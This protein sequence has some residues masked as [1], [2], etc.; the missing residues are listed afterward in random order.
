MLLS[1][2]NSYAAPIFA[3]AAGILGGWLLRCQFGNRLPSFLRSRRRS[4]D[5]AGGADACAAT[6]NPVL[7][8]IDQTTPTRNSIEGVAA[9]S[10]RNTFSLAL[11]RHLPEAAR[12]GAALSVMFVRIDNPRRP[13]D[14]NVL[15]MDNRILDAT[16]KLFVGLVRVTDWV[17]RFDATTFAFLLT[18]TEHASALMVAE[19]CARSF[20]PW[21]CL[22]AR[23]PF[24]SLLASE[25]R[26]SCSATVVL[27]SCTAPR[28]P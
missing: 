24:G 17:A 12:R 13:G 27:R 25:R 28:K 9:P 14:R 15:P 23:G 11:D 6:V 19:R 2:T 8:D 22:P 20:P 18:D 5:F 3:L 16:G 1:S 4:R 26:I 7:L 10:V 21:R